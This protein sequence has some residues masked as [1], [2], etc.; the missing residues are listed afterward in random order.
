MLWTS[1]KIIR[2]ADN[3]IIGQWAVRDIRPTGLIELACIISE[4]YGNKGYL[5]ELI[6]S[7]YES[8]RKSNNPITSVH[9]T[10]WPS[11]NSL[12]FKF[13]ENEDPCKLY[14]SLSRPAT[15][16]TLSLSVLALG[17][18]LFRRFPE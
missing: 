1:F 2:K 10:H 9:T 16:A 4:P 14:K 5:E 11:K 13:N 3:Q 17:S 8:S 7:V 15:L 18:I 12:F 6:D